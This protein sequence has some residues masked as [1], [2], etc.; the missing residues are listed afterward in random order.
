MYYLKCSDTN[1]GISSV[2]TD[3]PGF[4]EGAA[5]VFW[6]YSPTWKK[7]KIERKAIKAVKATVPKPPNDRNAKDFVEIPI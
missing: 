2:L 3:T 6:F 4:Q 7:R 5:W 1:A